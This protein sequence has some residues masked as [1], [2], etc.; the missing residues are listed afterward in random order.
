[1]TYMLL[2]W[3]KID[4]AKLKEMAAA[5]KVIAPMNLP[6]FCSTSRAARVIAPGASGSRMISCF[7]SVFQRLE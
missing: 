5:M 4:G 6:F 2:S 7:V 3:G 1:M